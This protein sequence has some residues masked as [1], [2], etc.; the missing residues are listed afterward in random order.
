M[1]TKGLNGFAG[2][3]VLLLQ[4]PLGPFFRR[5]SRDLKENGARVSKINFNGGDWLFYPTDAVSFRGRMEDWP[6]FLGQ[7]LAE[8]KVDVVRLRFTRTSHWRPTSVSPSAG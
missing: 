4:G 5:L 8:R 3:H 7:L 1:V 2:K 6:V